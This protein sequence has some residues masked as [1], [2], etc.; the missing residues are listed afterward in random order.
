MSSGRQYLVG[1]DDLA[2][3]AVSVAAALAARANDKV[4]VIHFSF[5]QHGGPVPTD[6][7][8]G[9]QVGQAI[10]PVMQPTAEAGCMLDV[11][12]RHAPRASSLICQGRLSVTAKLDC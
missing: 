6:V 1:A 3:P 11:E 9:T 10:C 5:P 12:R 7:L 8:D 2:T 4:N